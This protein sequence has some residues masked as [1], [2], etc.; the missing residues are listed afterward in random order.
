MLLISDVMIVCSF[1][2]VWFCLCLLCL[3]DL[4]VVC[5]GSLFGVGFV[6]FLFWFVV[7]WFWFMLFVIV[8][9]FVLV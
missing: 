4:V 5:V 3:A 6:C 2:L 1:R 7:R 9:G 8:L